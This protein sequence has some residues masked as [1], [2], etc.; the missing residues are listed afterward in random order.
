MVLKDG[1]NLSYKLKGW[2]TLTIAATL[3]YIYIL[4]GDEKLII[5]DDEDEY[6]VVF[7]ATYINQAVFIGLFIMLYHR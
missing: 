6:W 3:Y 1:Y 7:S 5:V 4:W 2:Y